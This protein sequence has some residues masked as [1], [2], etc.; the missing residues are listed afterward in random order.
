MKNIAIA[1]NI[2]GGF[3]VDSR[4]AVGLG[5]FSGTI[6]DTFM[7]ILSY[8]KSDND[9]WFIGGVTAI[10]RMT[11]H[12]ENSVKSALKYLKDER[13]ILDRE[14]IKGRTKCT[15]YRI[16]FEELRARGFE[17]CIR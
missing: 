14:K 5:L 4:L 10:S 12:S 1:N 13:L 3:W 17:D 11:L 15:D 7:L 6:R 2:N 16:N 9:E 8:S